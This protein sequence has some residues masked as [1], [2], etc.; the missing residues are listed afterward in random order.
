MEERVSLGLD[1]VSHEELQ[2]TVKV[3]H[4]REFDSP[5]RVI[6]SQLLLLY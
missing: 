1:N 3:A 4:V 6:G 2:V 5:L